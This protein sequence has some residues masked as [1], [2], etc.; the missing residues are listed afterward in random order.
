MNSNGSTQTDTPQV[1]QALPDAS[2]EE[3]L[4]ALETVVGHLEDGNLSLGATIDTFE[5]GMRLAERCRQL[6][7]HAELRISQIETDAESADDDASE[8]LGDPLGLPF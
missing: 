2:F 5:Q 6:L 8:R 7:A 4:A 3:S 1:D